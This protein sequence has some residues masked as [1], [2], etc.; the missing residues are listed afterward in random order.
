MLSA[1]SE[2]VNIN[3]GDGDKLLVIYGRITDGTAGNEV[4]ISLT[5]P[6][7]GEAEPV[8]GASIS[9]LED[10]LI[11][12]EF[13]EKSPG[14]YRLESQDSA[15]EGRTYE[16]EVEL[17]DGREYRSLPATM[18]GLAAIDKPR[19]DASVVEVEVNQAGLEVKKNLIQLFVDTEIVDQEND[20][21]LKWDIVETY[22]FQE[23]IRYTPI[24]VPPC[25]ITNNTTG[26]EIFLFNG[27]EIKVT[28]IKDQLISTSEIDSR[29]AFDY[30][31]SVI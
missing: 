30:Y 24:P 6:V 8:S 28:E 26:Q 15:M 17:S 27:E 4:N 20:F 10:G 13:T 23:R 14:V 19:F 9:L 5:S 11:F 16:I 31:F 2:P 25:Y 29:F 21:Y 3:T 7:N 18:P 1:C 22:S 12:G